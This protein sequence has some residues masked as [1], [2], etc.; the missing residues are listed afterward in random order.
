MDDA[1]LEKIALDAIAPDPDQ[2]R[3]IPLTLDELQEQTEAGD[4]RAR[5]IWRK[6][7][8]LATSIL[9]V[10]LQQPISVYPVGEDGKYV[11]YDGHR[12]WLALTFLRQQGQVDDELVPCY[13]R[14]N[15]ESEDDVLLNRLNV[16]IQREDFDVF[17]LARGLKQ[18][19]DNLKA[20]GGEVR[21]VREDGSIEV[22]TI[23]DGKPN[24]PNWEIW[25]V[26][27]RKMGIGRTRRYQIQAVLKLPPRVQRIAENA[28]IPESKLRYLI[29]IKDERIL[30]VI[31]QEMA[32]K[33]MSNARIRRRIKELQ[34]ELA[35]PATVAM[36]KPIQIKSRI[37][38]VKKLAREISMVQNVPAAI[39]AKDP[40][41]VAGYKELIP[42]LQAA[43]K[44][45]EAV[46]A[47]LELPKVV[48]LERTCLCI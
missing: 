12:R 2:P 22:V 6:L 35:G 25:D 10:G 21:L 24:R 48:K 31:V 9:E 46:L 19:H 8:N 5:A 36:P 14:P 45:L 30:D 4:H 37:K 42:E 1:R 38:P 18:V 11:I 20:N 39:S 43:I 13:V 41:T 27:E 17:E 23:E 7:T 16:N 28:A 29:P 26:V 15:P 40:R 32:K 47:K 34:R 44:D 33:K 3:N